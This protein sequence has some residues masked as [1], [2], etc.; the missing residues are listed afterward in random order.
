MVAL[1]ARFTGMTDLFSAPIHVRSARP[2][3]AQAIAAMSRAALLEQH[4]LPPGEDDPS[5]AELAA[6]TADEL[7]GGT[8]L[9]LLATRLEVPV[10]FLRCRCGERMWLLD[11]VYVAPPHRGDG[12]TALLLEELD[13]RAYRRGLDSTSVA[14]SLEAAC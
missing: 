5:L 11:Q 12:V 8:V 9:Y 13:R 6:R 3:D 1:K 4:L 7:E 2:Q 14:I 10:A